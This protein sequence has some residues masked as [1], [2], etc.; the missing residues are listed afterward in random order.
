MERA[1]THSVDHLELLTPQSMDI[2]LYRDL[3]M[4]PQYLLQFTLRE[5]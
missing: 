5:P 3:R 1:K 4:P 2:L